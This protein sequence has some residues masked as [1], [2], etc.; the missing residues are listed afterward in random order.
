MIKGKMKGKKL[1]LDLDGVLA[2]FTYQAFKC[3]GVNENFYETHRG[4]EYWDVVKISQQTPKNFWSPMGY[5][6]WYS[7]PLTSD[8]E[9]IYRLCV[10][11]FGD[12]IAFLTSPCLT[13]GCMEGKR[14]WCFRHFPGVPIIFSHSSG[15]NNL[16]PKY[17]LAHENSILVDDYEKNVNSWI[18]HGG[19]GFLY[20][21]PWNCKSGEV[22]V[23]SLSLFLEDTFRDFFYYEN[24]Y[25]YSDS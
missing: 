14:D 6:F 19:I 1:L 24:F 25:W 17:F 23:D 22:G 18:S 3:H 11:Y 2:N 13:N 5:D 21:R 20:P 16:P 4:S 8:A 12:S 10:E 9:K 7:M 15:E